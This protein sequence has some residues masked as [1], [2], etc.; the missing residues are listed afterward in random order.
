MADRKF[1]KKPNANDLKQGDKAENPARR[2]MLVGSGALLVGGVAGRASAQEPR[3]AE[4]S[5]P[6]LPWP[7][8]KIDP[9]EAGSRTYDAYLTQGG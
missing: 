8:T 9:M 4:A 6:P 3:P 7:W 5:A 2:N 1:D